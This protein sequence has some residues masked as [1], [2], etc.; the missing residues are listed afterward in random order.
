[1]MVSDRVL[2]VED[3]PSL[4]ETIAYS[5]SRQGYDVFEVGD[6]VNQASPV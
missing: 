1:M 3:E 5:L 4:R 6:G 2:I